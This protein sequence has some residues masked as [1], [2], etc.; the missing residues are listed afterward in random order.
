[1]AKLQQERPQQRLRAPRCFSSWKSD[2]ARAYH[3]THMEAIYATMCDGYLRASDST[4]EFTRF[5]Q[6]SPGVYIHGIDYGKA[7]GYVTYMPLH[8]DGIYWGAKWEV[9]TDRADRVKCDRR[10]R[11]VCKERSVKLEALWICGRKAEQM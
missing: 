4:R 6:E 5:A 1:M 3:G 9:R 7:N 10:K 11:W 2:W 8:N